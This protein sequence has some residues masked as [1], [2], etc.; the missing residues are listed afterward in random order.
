MLGL[1]G[2]GGKDAPTTG[3]LMIGDQ[4]P[5]NCAFCAQA[6]GSLAGSGRL[7]RVTWPEYELADVLPALVAAC[8]Q[9]LLLRLC[10]QTVAGEDASRQLAELVPL[11][12][13]LAGVPVS[14]SV[15]IRDLQS[16]EALLAS[17][18]QRVGLALDAATGDIYAQTK[19]GSFEAAREL[20][21]RAAEAYPGR[22]STHLI[23]G[24]GE[25]ERDLLTQLQWCL[26][27]GILVGLFAFTPVPG[28]AL[29]ARRAPDLSSFRRLQAAAHLLR[30]GERRAEQL[31]F[32]AG[33]ELAGMGQ[34]MSA[35]R[36]AELLG[37]GAAFRTSGCPGCNRPYYNE[38]PGKVP[39]NYA[40][41]LGVAEARE[42]VGLVIGLAGQDAA[43]NARPRNPEDEIRVER[44][45][46]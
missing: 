31:V 1:R 37:D 39:Y 33:G 8:R 17:G 28:T 6:R 25:T 27:R 2:G 13:D 24:L 40:R 38:R 18:L 9:G 30:L 45:P 11:L 14:A 32:D 19:G 42:A 21:A 23:A 22:V 44:P 7:S 5:R 20:L 3:Y 36:L 4:C 10:V 12:C 35:E 26:D 43:A 16:L 41:P 15:Y 46:R 29:E 34:G